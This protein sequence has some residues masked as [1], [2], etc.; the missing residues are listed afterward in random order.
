LTESNKCA[1]IYL[2]EIIIEKGWK[3]LGYTQMKIIAL[4]EGSKDICERMERSIEEFPHLLIDTEG[5]SENRECRHIGRVIQNF[6]NSDNMILLVR[7]SGRHSVIE[8][9]GGDSPEMII[10]LSS[11]KEKTFLDLVTLLN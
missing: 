1:I 6:S 11:N 9:V 2:C 10:S 8:V 3:E 7:Y 5:E 4:V